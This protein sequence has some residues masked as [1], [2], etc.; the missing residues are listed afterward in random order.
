MP[1]ELVLHQGRTPGGHLAAEPPA[2][3]TQ[4][5]GA[6]VFASLK[7]EKSNMVALTDRLPHACM[8][9]QVGLGGCA[10]P[11]SIHRSLSGWPALNFAFILCSPVLW[12][13]KS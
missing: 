8:C 4:P 5:H 13:Q 3:G 2:P 11:P 10:L 6:T 1:R 7:W 12:A 9:W